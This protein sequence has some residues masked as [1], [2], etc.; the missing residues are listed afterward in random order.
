MLNA[1]RRH[2]LLHNVGVANATGAD[3]AQRLSA[4]LSSSRDVI[5][6]LEHRVEVLNAFRRHCL[7]HDPADADATDLYHVLNAFR[8]HCL[9]HADGG[10][11]RCAMS[12]MCSTP[13]GVT[14]FF[15]SVAR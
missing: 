6:P 13:F 10:G 14:V 3:G 9:L 15:T 5:V 4:S 7:L 11:C 8:R 12:L 1:F 2:C